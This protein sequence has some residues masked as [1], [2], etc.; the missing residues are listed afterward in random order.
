MVRFATRAVKDHH[1]RLA[2]EVQEAAGRLYD[3]AN[4]ERLRIV[5]DV[6]GDQ[7]IGTGGNGGL[8][9]FVVI[10]IRQGVLK[11]FAVDRNSELFY[12]LEQFLNVLRIEAELLSQHDMTV[13][14]ENASIVAKVK[15]S[16]QNA[17]QND[18][19]R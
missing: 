12:G 16:P 8:E 1:R 15:L 19:G 13:L 10:G 14:P 6:A 7:V 18:V 3:N 5:S 4:A 11:R 9:K 2:M 17:L